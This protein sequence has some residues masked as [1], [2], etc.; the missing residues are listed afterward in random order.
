MFDAATFWDGLHSQPRFQLI[1]PS[2][3]VVRFLARLR[4]ASTK[5]TDGR[6]LDIGCG[7]GRHCSLLSDFKYSPYG[8]DISL[9]ALGRAK[10]RL[11]AE[12]KPT[13][14]LMKASMWEVPFSDGFFD[15]V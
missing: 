6:G 15:V 14:G 7:G 11:Q 8:I 1:H 13:E 4:R 2:E 5:R 3:H 10:A 9:S 12:G